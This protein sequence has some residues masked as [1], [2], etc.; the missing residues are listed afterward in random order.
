M[1]LSLS[2]PQLEKVVI[3]RSLVGKL[4]SDTISDGNYPHVQINCLHQQWGRRNSVSTGRL[5]ITTGDLQTQ[6]IACNS[7]VTTPGTNTSFDRYLISKFLSSVRFIFLSIFH[8]FLKTMNV[9]YFQ[10]NFFLVCAHFRYFSFH[11]NFE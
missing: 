6:V 4:I 3:D 11:M 10:N 7:I 1:S 8:S 2:G 5:I 9:F